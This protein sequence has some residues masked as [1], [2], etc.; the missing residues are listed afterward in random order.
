MA[1]AHKQSALSLRMAARCAAYWLPVMKN[2]GII[3]SW[4]SKYQVASSGLNRDELISDSDDGDEV[5]NRSDAG[6]LNVDDI[7]DF[8]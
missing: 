8:D 3:P 6:D 2:H 7:L 4:G 5:D 1:Y